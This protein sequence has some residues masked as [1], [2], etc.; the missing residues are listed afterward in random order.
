MIRLT[1]LGTAAADTDPREQY[2][3]R[4]SVAGLRG[5]EK[6]TKDD[7]GLVG[8][9]RRP[10]PRVAIDPALNEIQQRAVGNDRASHDRV[11][12]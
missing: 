4:T 11:L 5:E 6:L 9:V 10:W 3:T 8:L 7:S 2:A 1:F 12:R